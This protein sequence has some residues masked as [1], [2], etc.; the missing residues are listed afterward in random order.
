MVGNAVV[1]AILFMETGGWS[2][3]V[4]GLVARFIWQRRPSMAASYLLSLAVILHYVS[5]LLRY[6]PDGFV[7]LGDWSFGPTRFGV[8]TILVLGGLVFCWRAMSGL[9]RAFGVVAILA[10]FTVVYPGLVFPIEYADGVG[11]ETAHSVNSVV[12]QRLCQC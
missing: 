8:M 12:V 4:I 9:G 10:G 2:A 5:W 6:H 1:I 7:L 11:E 3:L